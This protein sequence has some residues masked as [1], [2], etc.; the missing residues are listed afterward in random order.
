MVQI[1]YN[2]VAGL[3]VTTQL[4]TKIFYPESESKPHLWSS[5]QLTNCTYD[6]T[7]HSFRADGCSI[8]LSEVGNSYT[9]TSTVNRA[10]VVNLTITRT[11]PGFMLGKNG[12]S[13]YG[14][15]P[16]NPRGYMRHAFWPRCSVSGTIVTAG[17]GPIDMSGKGLFI[18]AIQ[19]MKPHHAAAKWNFASMHTKTY[20]AVMMEF[21]TPASYGYTTVN[22]GGIV[23]DTEIL[24]AGVDNTVVHEA[25]EQDAQNGWAA[26][27]AASY[28]WGPQSGSSAPGK[29]VSGSI[30]GKLAP[31]ADKV[32]VMAEVP[33]F[34]KQIVA[35]AAGT[36]PYIYQVSLLMENYTGICADCS[37][38]YIKSLPFKVVIDGEE[39]EEQGRLYAEATYI[40]NVDAA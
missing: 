23:T 31:R 27:T 5:D 35:T 15:D 10:S 24:Y 40:T 28:T 30:Q 12:T 17:E 19:G 33:K 8:T 26:P 7:K 29:K 25:T 18:P 9:L 14:L 20:S 1:I 36:R 4:T 16:S 13:T 34:V 32:D 39:V 3:K 6:A 38:Q 2:N 37:M 21:T 11:A 22:V